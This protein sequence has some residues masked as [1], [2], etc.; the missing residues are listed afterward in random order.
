MVLSFSAKAV[1]PAMVCGPLGEFIA[2]WVATTL[3]LLS[4]VGQTMTPTYVERQGPVFSSRTFEDFTLVKSSAKM[5]GGKA[6][7]CGNPCSGDYSSRSK[8]LGSGRHRWFITCP[9]CKWTTD[10]KTPDDAIISK[11][12][13]DLIMKVPGADYMRTPFPVPIKV[14]QW[15]PPKTAR[16]TSASSRT[17]ANISATSSAN[18]SP[19][20]TPVSLH[21]EL[22]NDQTNSDPDLPGPKSTP[23]QRT[24]FAVIAASEMVPRCPKTQVPKRAR[25]DSL[26]PEDA[27]DRGE[28][29]SRTVQRKRSRSCEFS[30]FSQIFR[31]NRPTETYR[32]CL[33]RRKNLL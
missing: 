17:S 22:Q 32:T 26:A 6:L 29:G 13:A 1:L 4:I 31:A 12:D 3:P 19:P 28:C 10:Y 25:V 24:A 16:S 30:R 21:D 27:V 18:P 5:V 11:E 7:N 23:K 8:K 2:K 14:L 20:A 9:G 33:G 15:K